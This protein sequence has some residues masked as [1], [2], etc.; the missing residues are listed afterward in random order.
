MSKKSSSFLRGFHN[1]LT[2]PD[3][4]FKCHKCDRHAGGLEDGRIYF[5]KK[6][7]CILNP[8]SS[9]IHFGKK[10]DRQRQPY[11]KVCL[12]LINASSVWTL[13]DRQEG[14]KMDAFTS[15]ENARVTDGH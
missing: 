6:R 7:A 2:R 14:W 12:I 4:N 1:I 3:P 10:I 11:L 15:S 9:H 5:I 8:N 13:C